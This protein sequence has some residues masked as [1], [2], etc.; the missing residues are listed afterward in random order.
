M[1][2]KL[3]IPNIISIFRICLIPVIVVLY[4]TKS[5]PNNYLITAAVIVFSGFTDILDG[6]IARQ[7]NMTSQL[8]KIL[9]PAADKLTQ[10]TVLICLCFN[11]HLLIPLAV[12]LFIKESALL[13]GAII[14]RK[15]EGVKTPGAKWWGKLSTV[16]VYATMFAT[17]VSDF[18]PKFPNAVIWALMAVSIIAVTMSFI[19]YY[20]KIYREF[21]NSS[22]EI[23]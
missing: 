11:H 9:D 4:F 23:E 19:G 8:G 22:G 15:K 12:L 10:A 18:V 20:F 7:F 6:F 21:R 13:A 3:T 16:V 1:K 14:L 17:V 5:L 2:K